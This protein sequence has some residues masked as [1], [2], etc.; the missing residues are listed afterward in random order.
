MQKMDPKM[1]LP[2]KW[3]VRGLPRSP[4]QHLPDELRLVP[5]VASEPNAGR[6]RE[7]RGPSQA[8]GHRAAERELVDA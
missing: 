5:R 4:A 1:E 8:L 2:Q 6:E 7:E 3:G